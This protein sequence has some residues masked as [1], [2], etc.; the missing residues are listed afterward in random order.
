MKQ[1]FRSHHTTRV[2]MVNTFFLY[3][4]KG[5]VCV[6]KFSL[7]AFFVFLEVHDH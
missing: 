7:Y 5:K 6:R 3:I 1:N 4:N 2:R